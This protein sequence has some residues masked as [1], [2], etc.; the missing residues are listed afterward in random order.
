MDDAARRAQVEPE[1]PDDVVQGP[2]PEINSGY[3]LTFDGAFQPGPIDW[4]AMQTYMESQGP[5]PEIN[6]GFAD[7]PAPVI[8]NGSLPDGWAAVIHARRPVIR[9]V[10]VRP[11]RRTAPR[12]L[13]ARRH[14]RSARRLQKTGTDDSGPSDPPPP[15]IAL[16]PACAARAAA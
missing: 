15:T 11:M 5:P 12:R 2:R 7:P 13:G 10:W 6:S 9:R 4:S 3:C 1:Q 8:F 14:R 16:R